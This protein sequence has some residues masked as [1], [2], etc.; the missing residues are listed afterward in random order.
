MKDYKVLNIKGALLDKVQLENYLEKI[1]SDHVLQI[2]SNKETYPIPRLKE[3]YEVITQIYEL[4]TEHI[5][6][7]I[8]IHPA[9][10]WILDNYYII[11]EAVKSIVKD[12][13]LKKYI[14]FPGIA[15]GPYAGFARIYEL[16]GEIV[17][18]TDCKIDSKTLPELLKAYQSKKNLNMEEIWNIGP[19]IQIALIEKIREVCEKIYSSQMQKYKVENIVERLVQEKDKDKCK[20][21][22]IHEYRV[23]IIGYDE[24]KYPFIEYMSYKLKKMGRRAYPFLE[25]LEDEVNKMGLD[26]SDVIK[27]EHFNIAVK[28][29]IV[30]NSITSIKAINRMNFVNIFE[31]INGVEEILKKDPTETY[32]KMDYKT[33]IYYRNAIKTIAK[34]TGISEIYVAQKALELANKEFKKENKGILELKK[35]HI[36]YYLISDGKTKLMQEVTNKKIDAPS[37]ENK[38]KLYIYG[39]IILAI[40]LTA[41]IAWN[42]ERQINNIVITIII[43]V[44]LFI[45]LQVL[46]QQIVQYILGKFVRPKIIPKLDFSSGIPEE[47]ATFVV[48]PTILNS[49]QK[50]DELVKKLE[51]YYLANKTDNLYLAILGD[52]K[53]SS[54]K[55]EEIDEKIIREGL[56][57]I[58]QLN[59]KYKD[60]KFPKFHFLYRE[61]IWN[62]GEACYLGWERKR[63]LLN[64]FNEFMKRGDNGNFKVNTIEQ[65]KEKSKLPNIKYVITL[66]SD[67]N[68]V[69]NSGLELVG[70]MAHILNL[71]VLNKNNTVV[72]NGHA[73]IQPRVGI[74][75]EI[76]NKTWFTK[77][78]AGNGGTDPYSN[79]ISDT[80]QDNFGEGIFTGKGIYNLD[81]FYDVFKNTIPD[82]TVLSHDLLE[83][84]YLRCGLASDI[85]LMDG[86]PTTYQTF[87]MRLSR[88]IRG[89]WQIIGWL[90]KR[91]LDKHKDKRE[92]PLNKLSKYKILDNLFRSIL[93]ISSILLIFVSII[94]WIWKK[95]NIWPI[96][97]VAI[98][99]VT[100]PTIID[101]INKIIFYKEGEKKQKTFS[102]NVGNFKASILRG[103]FS[104]ALL[105]DRAYMSLCAIVRTIYR[106]YRSKKSLL[107]WTTAEE[108]ENSKKA[109]LQSYYASMGPNLVLALIVLG[110]TPY[111]HNIFIDI[112]LVFLAIIWLFAPL[113]MWYISKDFVTGLQIDKISTKDKEYIV[114]IAQKTWNFFKENLT[115]KSNYLPPD[116]FQEDRIPKLVYRTS[117]TNIGLALLAVISSYDLNFENI[118]NT[119]K[120]LEKILN[121]ISELP[122]WNGHLYNWYDIENLKPLEPKYVSSVDSGNFIGYL[123]V[124]KE[125]LI[126]LEDKYPNIK[127]MVNQINNIIDCTDFSKLY[128]KENMLFSIGFNVEENSLTDSYYDLLASEARQTSLV[129]IAKKD[130]DAKHWNNLSRTLTKFK[131]YKGLLSWSGTSFEYLMPNVNI[132]KYPGSLLDES[133]KF[134][135]MSQQEYAKL[136]NIPWGFSEAAF[137]LKD[138]NN[139]YQYKAFGI[140]WLGLKRGLSEEIVVAPYGSIMALY[141]EP[142]NV[143]T[144]LK[145]LQKKNMYNKYG[146]YESI[147]YTSTR[148][149][150]NEEFADVKTYMAHHQGLILLSI[151]NLI[152]NNILPKRFMENPEMKAID[153][154]LQERMPES[155]IVTKEKKEKVE[156]VVNF[157]YESYTQREIS[158]INSNLKQINVISNNN[159]AIVMDEKGNG[160]SKYKD[161]LINRYKK[162]DDIEQG[163]FFYFKNIRSKRIWT[164][165]YMSYLN[166]PDKYTIYF[167]PDS[168]KIIR[169][170]GNIETILKTTIS[171]N[172]PVELRKVK[173]TNTGLTE[174][175][176]EITSMLEPMLSKREQDYAHKVFNNLFLS[177]EWLEKPEILLIKRNSRGDNEKDI[178]LALNLYTENETIGEIEF[179]TDKEK[180]LGRNNMGLPKEVENST[181]F[182]KKMGTSTETVA[183]MKRMVNI[184]PEQSVEFNLIIAVGENREEALGRVVEFKNEEK[185]KRSFNLA[186]AKVEAE[187]SY[188]GIKG[189]DVE[190]YQKILRYLIYTNPLKTVLYK[191]RTN[192]H[193]LVEDLWKYGISGDIP[194][195][196]VKIK[197]V[198]DIDIVKETIKAYDYFRI[199]NIE[200]D[201][202][203]INEEKN[204]YNNYVK[205]GVQ[206]AIFNQGLGFMQ[207]IKGGIFLL[208]GLSKKDKESIE[209]RS[210]L[211]INAE[212][213]SILRQINDLEEEYLENVKEIGDESNLVGVQSEDNYANNLIT[214]ELKY[215]NDYGGFSEDG[216]EYKIKVSKDVKLPTVWSHVLANKNFGSVITECMGGYTWFKNSRL[217]RLT[218][219]NNNPVTDVPSEIIY[220]EDMDSKK[221]WSMGLNPVPD[222]SPYYITYGF[223]Y[224]KYTHISNGLKQNLDVFVPMNENAKIQVLTLENTQ[225]KKKEIKLVYYLKPVLDEDEIKSNG[226]QKLD[227]NNKFN[228]LFM[229]NITK[230][231][232]TNIM[233][234]SSSESIQSYTGSKQSFFGKG[235][236]QS[237]DAL[238]KIELDNKNSLWQDGI[239]AIELKVEIEA[240][241]KK[242]IVLMMGAGESMLECQDTAYKYSNLNNVRTEFMNVKKYWNNL[243]NHL[244]VKTPVESMNIMLNGWLLY[245]TI[246]SRIWAR[247]GYYQSGGAFGFRDQL[248]DSMA[249]KYADIEIMKNQIIKHSEHQFLEGDVEHWWHDETGRG[250]RTRFSDDLLWLVY[251]VLDYVY[252]SGNKDILEI[253]TPYIQG[254]PLEEGVDERYDKY[255][256]SDVVEDIY[257]HCIRAIEHSLKFGENG[258]PKMGSGDWNDGLNK[259]GNKGKGESVWLGFFMYI[260]LRRFLPICR[261][262]GEEERAKRYEEISEKLR[263]ALNTNGWDGRWY[264]RAF[265]DNGEALGSI[266]NEECKIDSISQ[267]WAT[268]SKAGDNDKKYIALESLEN[269]LVDRE[270]GI[271]KLLDPPFNKG[272]IDPGYIK[273]YLPGIRE[274]G[275]QYTHGAIW[276][277]IAECMLGFG[278]KGA[279]F[280]RMINPIEHSRTKDS[281]NK[282]K[283]EP[284]VMAADIYGQG[285]LAGRGGWTWYTGSSSWMYEAG[286]KY[287]LGLNIVR[288]FLRIK[289]CIPKEWKEYSIKYRYGSSIYNITVKNENGKNTGVER[290]VLNGE[291]IPDKQVKLN[292]MGGIYHIDII[293]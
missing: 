212:M 188:L 237:P 39:I 11:E 290:F 151:N 173:L 130:V 36:G 279:E 271:I 67:T 224:A 108:A 140:P 142:V 8:P 127:N 97:I 178:Y 27:K 135:I 114:D 244:Q 144:N 217:N 93:E 256:K 94:I 28:K 270:N 257:N 285:S 46:V 92:N 102:K 220:F 117:P 227:Y 61:R 15:T 1:A 104:I 80:Y 289:P 226:Y 38:I 218:A 283:V 177:Y 100:I 7:Q 154:L 59:E 248:Q 34:K 81:V 146:F 79:A 276:V 128:N 57:K 234:V 43:A 163:I 131:N 292:K 251:V 219:W 182:S 111:I 105:P 264:K 196:L 110:I 2:K 246:C 63:G 147:D 78:Y 113:M 170:D 84:N 103:V 180:F 21:K 101:I 277:I 165:S 253:E 192:E 184:L 203:I 225:L 249:T 158:K 29:V 230:P 72:E 233:W 245:Q 199:K 169:Q 195:L 62:D 168:N 261:Y 30:G 87:K 164:T 193:A 282:Y 40:T 137:N 52:C 121:T 166:K 66:D 16:A 250:I 129:A 20:F 5:K 239:I 69:L 272:S 74:D 18:Y 75:L 83:G 231:L 120:L 91:V 293:M 207:N 10:E 265:M 22:N 85:E 145:E 25:V 198:N 185:I 35:S 213:G 65:A 262:R 82:N 49:V 13:T 124:V 17:A 206:N 186:R 197:D 119:V 152:N 95:A 132:P 112:F 56:K 280:F 232:N 64:Q 37:N 286:I 118:D 259:V 179:E 70:A 153:I 89:D 287:I 247:S 252:F 200:I 116:N 187:N 6:L 123:Y 109:S 235:N 26:I 222:D 32:S 122:K 181:P 241:S 134:M 267:S 281:A 255:I 106:M 125:F 205:E 174:E 288:D 194:I 99:A 77:I 90:R 243:V 221:I 45:P 209:Y 215:D 254:A 176:I 58:D 202:V 190:L 191:G 55:V 155:L 133:C 141:D 12:I 167:A 60:D 73:L 236:L 211:V 9:G 268:I 240:L 229:Q 4:L 54:Q 273:S 157:D 42:I 96:I 172:E 107:E 269:H 284:Y 41:L 33:R 214:E 238:R 278:D 148:L 86:Y 160:Y 50:V 47:C 223:G 260:I 171:P 201:L 71:P 115:E 150:K 19:F 208:N 258:L 183:A 156:R 263:K 51:V 274:N 161:I 242:E 204:S 98:T 24:M 149:R 162:T 3:N 68:L 53:P 23:K 210:N 266:E 159:Y 275:G 48:I 139:N 136:L 143:I 189:K 14:N 44:L 31:E 228:M 175:I 76:S 216:T 138:L 291:E 126:E 88:W